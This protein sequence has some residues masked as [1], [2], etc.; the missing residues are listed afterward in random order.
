MKA[1]LKETLVG[2]VTILAFTGVLGV[3]Y[4]ARDVPATRNGY[5]VNATFN[6]IDGLAEGAEVRLGGIPIGHV[7]TTTLSG[8]YRAVVAMRIENGVTLPT[9][10]AVAIHTDGLFGS[11]YME[12]EPGGEEKT[13]KDG[14]TISYAQDAV[15]VT[16]LLNRIIAQGEARLAKQKQQQ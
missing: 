12:L 2:V 15:V 16:D 8:D 14:E 3:S 4:A 9:D 6:L 5:V 10:T 11:K 1:E 13:L 7:E